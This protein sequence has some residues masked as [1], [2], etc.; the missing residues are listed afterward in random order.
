[1]DVY[2]IQNEIST[3]W[4]P[5][6]VYDGQLLFP[7]VDHVEALP[8]NKVTTQKPSTDLILNRV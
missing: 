8:R 6:F 7:I 3:G 2:S 1:M 5:G 4:Q